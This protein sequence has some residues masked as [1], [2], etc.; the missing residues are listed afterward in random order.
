MAA[1]DPFTQWKALCKSICKLIKEKQ[2]N[3]NANKDRLVE[4]MEFYFINYGLAECEDLLLIYHNLKNHQ[5]SL[6]KL[7]CGA[8][9]CIECYYTFFYEKYREGQS[10]DCSCKLRIVPKYKSKIDSEYKRLQGLKL[11]CRICLKR[12]DKMEFAVYAA[13]KCNVCSDCMSENYVYEKGF[14]NVCR[15]CNQVYDIESDILARNVYESKLSP[16]R[17]LAFHTDPC[18]LCNTPKDSR[19]FYQIC[20]TPHMACQECSKILKETQAAL[21]KI[22]NKTISIIQLIQGK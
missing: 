16:E 18:S 20:E 10:L 22:C 9:H 8:T 21:C 3:I 2:I 14:N 15:L 11:D 5:N 19:T 1:I 7:A 17:Q 13:H 4:L 6:L 12:K